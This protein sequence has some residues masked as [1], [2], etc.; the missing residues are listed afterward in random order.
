MTLPI[1]VCAYAIPSIYL[2]FLPLPDI[3]E[4]V[5][6]ILQMKLDESSKCDFIKSENYSR[7]LMMKKKKGKVYELSD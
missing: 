2:F 6:L 5:L 3:S 7:R 4:A 1:A